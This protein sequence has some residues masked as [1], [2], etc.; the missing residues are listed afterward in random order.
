MMM[1]LVVWFPALK[2]MMEDFYAI[3]EIKEWIAVRP[4][5]D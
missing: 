3:K 4:A 5:M 2:K 1:H